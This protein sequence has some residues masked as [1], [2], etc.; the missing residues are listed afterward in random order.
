MSPFESASHRMLVH[1]NT[2][3]H[4]MYALPDDV[5]TVEG[6]RLSIV[7]HASNDEHSD[8][9]IPVLRLVFSWP[10]KLCLLSSVTPELHQLIHE[11]PNA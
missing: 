3:L 6:M 5:G 7:L 9:G 1:L 8:A 4:G 2:H 11:C 10:S